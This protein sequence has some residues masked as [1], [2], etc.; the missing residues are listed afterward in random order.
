MYWVPCL[1]EFYE[2]NPKPYNVSDIKSVANDLDH[3]ET[4]RKSVTP[5]NSGYGACLK[6]NGGHFEHL[7][8]VLV[9]SHCCTLPYLTLPYLPGKAFYRLALRPSGPNANTRINSKIT[10]FP[11]AILTLVHSKI[12]TTP[13]PS[14]DTHL[15][16]P[17]VTQSLGTLQENIDFQN[18]HSCTLYAKIFSCFW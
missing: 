17:A 11:S 3:K 1:A 18:S 14:K 10:K 7:F 8:Q 5:V 12:W 13:S 9:F 2:L 16:S 4:I 6:A 15:G